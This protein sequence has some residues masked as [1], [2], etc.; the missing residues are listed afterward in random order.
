MS[1][2]HSLDPFL[3]LDAWVQEAKEKGIPD[4]NAMVLATVSAESQ[5][6]NR[7]VLYKGLLHG[8]LS[9]YTNYEGRK[10]VDLAG[11]QKAGANFFW[12]PLSRQIR[13]EGTVSKLSRAESEAYFK[14]RPRLSQLGAWASN[15]SKEISG[16][17]ELE[18]RMKEVENKFKGQDVPCPPNW[19]G[20]L[21]TPAAFEFWIGREG[22]LHERYCF[23]RQGVD[24]RRFM[25][26]P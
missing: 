6:T 12:A 7:V 9:F 21:L 14:T 11:N 3:H 10:A 26:S 4:S 18:K 1:F 5:P 24:W 15:Q 2:N 13:I 8:G 16:I 17:D 22:R 23:E 19:G 25:R 20:Y